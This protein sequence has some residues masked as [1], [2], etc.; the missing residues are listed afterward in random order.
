MCIAFICLNLFFSIQGSKIEAQVPNRWV[1]TFEK[2][3]EQDVAY[4]I[5]NPQLAA[6]TCNTKFV[7]NENKISLHITTRIRRCSDYVG[8]LYGFSFEKYV[9]LLSRTI[10]EKT[11]VGQYK[12]LSLILITLQFVII[13]QYLQLLILF[14]YIIDVIGDVVRCFKMETFASKNNKVTRKMNLELQDLE[15]VFL[16]F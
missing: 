15:Y 9:T 8:S 10:D 6:N 1:H 7:N 16:L 2:L 5:K 13:K 3:L 14:V 12:L 11:P 4:Y